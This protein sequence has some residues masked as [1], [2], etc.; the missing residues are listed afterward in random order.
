MFVPA[1]QMEL[2]DTLSRA[3]GAGDLTAVDNGDVE[4]HAASIVAAL[5]SEKTAALIIARETA[6]DAYLQAVLQQIMEG[7]PVT[8]QLKPL[9]SEL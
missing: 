4:V 6:S 2:P 9:P 5:A 7:K 8:G 3:P 1:K